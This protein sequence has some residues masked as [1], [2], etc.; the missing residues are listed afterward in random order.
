MFPLW[1]HL[2]FE[3]HGNTEENTFNELLIR[4]LLYLAPNCSVLLT[5]LLNRLTC[6]AFLLVGLRTIDILLKMSRSSY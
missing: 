6:L 1:Q 5:V 4:D 2:R 3:W